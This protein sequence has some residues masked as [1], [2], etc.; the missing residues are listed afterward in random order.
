MSA[1]YAFLPWLRRGIATAIVRKDGTV[2]NTPKAREMIVVA[3]SLNDETLTATTTLALL[4]PGDVTGLAEQAVLRTWPRPDVYDATSNFLPLAE[5]DQADLPWRF[6]PARPDDK[7]RLRPWLCLIVLKPD[8]EYK[9]GDPPGTTR[10]LNTIKVQA[11][12]PLPNLKQSWAWAHVQVSGVK[13]ITPAAARF[14]FATDPK[15]LLAR[16][17]C[18]RRLEPK[19]LYTGFLVPTFERGRL[20]GLGQPVPGSVDALAD[21]W[22]TG[23]RTTELELPV[24]YAWTFHSGEAQ[25]FEDL[26]R[27]LKQGPILSGAGKRD[28]DVSSPG[29]GR[30]PAAALPLGVEGALKLPGAASTPWDP[31][32]RSAWTASLKELVDTPTAL[33]TTGVAARHVAPPLYGRWHAARDTLGTFATPWSWFDEV[34]TD[35][36][37]RVVAAMGTRVVREQQQELMASAWR[38]VEGIRA[39][40]AE[41]KQAQLAREAARRIHARHIAAEDVEVVLQM[42]TPLHTRVL[43]P[44][45]ASGT[46]HSRLNQSPLPP[47]VLSAGWRRF[48]RPWG[49]LGRR[50][51]RA[52]EPR[53]ST[54]LSRLNRGELQLAVAPRPA[55]SMASLAGAK[56]PGTAQVSG[57]QTA[58]GG[59]AFFAAEY[60]PGPERTPPP[61]PPESVP[62][63]PDTGAGAAFRAAVVQGWAAVTATPPARQVQSIDL[64]ALR[65]RLIEQL[66]P[67][68]TFT[69][70]YQP[71][72]QI[73]AHLKWKPVDPLEPVLAAPQFPHPMVEPL[74]A[75]SQEWLVPG[76]D[77]VPRNSLSLLEMN[78]R[79]IYAYMLGLNHEMARELLWNEYPTDQRGTYFKQF[80]DPAAYTPKPTDPRQLEDIDPID[81]WPVASALEQAGKRTMLAASPLVLLIRGD[82]LM[83]Y[84]NTLL[85]GVQAALKTTGADPSKP[86]NRKLS[87]PQVESHPLF[88]GTLKP[89]VAY[90]AFDLTSDRVLGRSGASIVDPG[91][92][93]V[94]QE[95]DSEARF[96]LNVSAAA[97]FKTWD[98]L[99]WVDLSGPPA[100]GAYIDLDTHAPTRTPAAADNPEGAVWAKPSDAVNSATAADMALIYLQRQVRIAVHASALIRA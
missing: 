20:A 51:G 38:Q 97:L 58:G 74:R 17:M 60:P 6:T 9:D 86:E 92:Y 81:Q 30:V 46:I 53:L 23:A 80:W 32:Q 63:G 44:A 15:R 1:S 40:N 13:T 45:V 19:T 16:L 82:L 72:L 4:G 93:F 39:L 76:L 95:Q 88:S 66:N 62:G 25:D 84:P 49:P 65:A 79:F 96:G 54:V 61:T 29:A 69:A 90:Y 5:F 83:R 75:L 71:R 89:D 78:R 41:L 56:L 98:D 100:P 42:T 99:A 85:Y 35:P 87:D 50:Q 7:G 43:A 28:M 37:L 22:P 31:A 14:L 27:Q 73:A 55:R 10:P 34:N 47:G 11:S 59:P 18:P 57:L 67:D 94:L 52:Q 68:T 21:A 26:V 8:A 70:S 48:A 91:W 12:A 77:K 33:L 3:T 36:R 24:Y 2:A 64:A